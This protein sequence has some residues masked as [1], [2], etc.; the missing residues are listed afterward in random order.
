MTTYI[1]IVTYYGKYISGVY[2]TEADSEEEGV[3]KLNEAIGYDYH[4]KARWPMD[5]VA[6]EITIYPLYDTST[7]GVKGDWKRE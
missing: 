7:E 3:R 1:G 5:L 2:Q 6:P 4:I